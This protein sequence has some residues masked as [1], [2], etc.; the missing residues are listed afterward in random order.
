MAKKK[1]SLLDFLY[2][3]V[4]IFEIFLFTPVCLK[5]VYKQATMVYEGSTGLWGQLEL[6][7]KCYLLLLNILNMTQSFKKT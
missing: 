4:D 7:K 6:L 2:S 1:T 3:I 5:L